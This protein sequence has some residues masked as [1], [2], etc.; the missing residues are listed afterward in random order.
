MNEQVVKIEDIQ[1][2]IKSLEPSMLDLV[3]KFIDNNLLTIQEE[4]AEY[5][6]QQS[7]NIP[8]KQIFF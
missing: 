8:P 7:T 5:T 3:E 4:S 2:Y 6:S 1:Q